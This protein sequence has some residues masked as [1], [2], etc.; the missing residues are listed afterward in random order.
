MQL[1]TDDVSV[2]VNIGVLIVDGVIAFRAVLI[3][4]AR[5]MMK[6]FSDVLAVMSLYLVPVLPLCMLILW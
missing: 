2:S 6:L 5:I 3:L 1:L 4:V